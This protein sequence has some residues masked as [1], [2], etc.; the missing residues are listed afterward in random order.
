MAQKNH[1]MG[2]PPTNRATSEG[3]GHSP[4][5]PQPVPNSSAPMTSAR[6]ILG[7]RLMLRCWG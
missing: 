6:S 3:P 1:T 5:I 2:V 7:G 4:A